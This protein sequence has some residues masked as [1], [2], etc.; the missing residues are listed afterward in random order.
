MLSFGSLMLVLFF[1][2][3]SGFTMVLDK[4]AMEEK[5]CCGGEGDCPA[6]LCERQRE[7]PT[8]GPARVTLSMPCQII[9]VGGGFRTE[10]TVVEKASS[11]EPVRLTF[12][13]RGFPDNSVH[14]CLRQPYHR[15]ASA[16]E[17]A[18]LPSVDKCVFNSV[19]LI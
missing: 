15:S 9:A 19:F 12:L 4:C 13:P 8:S 3:N 1:L 16:S 10:P 2:A 7:S 6:G 14:L 18:G 17:A 5:N 11:P